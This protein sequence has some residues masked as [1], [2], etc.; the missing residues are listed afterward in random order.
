MLR[1]GITCVGDIASRGQGLQAM[2]ES[3]LHGISYCEFVGGYADDGSGRIADLVERADAAAALV[4]G[5]DAG[6]WVGLSPHAPYT[7]SM[8][9]ARRVTATARAHRWRLGCHLAESAAEVEFLASGGGPLAPFMG[10]VLELDGPLRPAE[11]G[12]TPLTYAE[13]VGLLQAGKSEHRPLIVHAAQL[14]EADVDLLAAAHVAVALCPRSNELLCVGAAAPVSR[15]AGAGIP[16]AVCTDSAAS[17]SGI[18]LFSELRA[19]Y[20]LWRRQE[21]LLE[22]DRAARRLLGMITVEAAQALDLADELGTLTPGKRADIAVV[23]R[24]AA[25][26]DGSRLV[27]AIVSDLDAGAVIATFTDGRRRHGREGLS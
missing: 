23:D 22:E 1:A 3:C 21:P 2:L 9:A 12:H 24:P 14:G 7:V 19:L 10:A 4:A 8:D 13:S 5:A 16:V 25:G 11:T 18:D 6:V 15:L 27:T 20:A 17:N 26:L